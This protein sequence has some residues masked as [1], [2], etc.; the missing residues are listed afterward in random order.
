MKYYNQRSQQHLARSPQS[1]ANDK[2]LRQQPE[3]DE[4]AREMGKAKKCSDSPDH[5]HSK[6][7][8]LDSSS[9]SSITSMISAPP[10]HDLIS[11]NKP[12]PHGAGADLMRSSE[13]P[14]LKMFH[15]S[16]ATFNLFSEH[17]EH[18]L[19][20]VE[21]PADLAIVRTDSTTPV[22]MSEGAGGQPDQSDQK[23]HMN[24]VFLYST[25]C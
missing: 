10:T 20:S 3:E 1:D 5:H 18:H 24:D 15:L 7:L 2:Q 16:P 12:A 8:I 17:S 14:N 9:V 21:P 23:R 4:T 25:Y 19:S 6:S 13:S 11:T 22:G